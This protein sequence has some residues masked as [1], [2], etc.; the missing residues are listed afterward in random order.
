VVPYGSAYGGITA[1]LVSC[2]VLLTSGDWH[3]T[4]ATGVYLFT[5]RPRVR[6][7]TADSAE[8]PRTAAALAL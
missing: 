7:S 2:R 8:L 3:A 6:R 4:H 1:S 5:P